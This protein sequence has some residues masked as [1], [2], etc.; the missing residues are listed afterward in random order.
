MESGWA[1]MALGTEWGLWMTMWMVFES[2]SSR[3]GTK[4]ECRLRVSPC[5]LGGCGCW[6]VLLGW[7]VLSVGLVWFV[8]WW[9]VCFVTRELFC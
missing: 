4:V 6:A 3:R 8:W 1:D 7:L 2:L 5:S 9:V